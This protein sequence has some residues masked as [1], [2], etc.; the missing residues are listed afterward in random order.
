ME[1]D[2]LHY[3][4]FKYLVYINTNSYVYQTAKFIIILIQTFIYI[5]V[6]I[7]ISIQINEFAK[8]KIEKKIIIIRIIIYVGRIRGGGE[9]GGGEKKNYWYIKILIK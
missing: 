4:N 8:I 2:R 9:R 7:S 5:F 3:I 6:L 1:K